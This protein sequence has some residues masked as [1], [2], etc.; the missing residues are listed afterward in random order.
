MDY[1][2]IVLAII[3]VVATVILFLWQTAEDKFDL[4]CILLDAKTGNVSLYKFGQLVALVISS[5]ALVNETRAG[6]LSEWLF[7]FYMTAWS[8]INLVNK[9]LDKKPSSEEPK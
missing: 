6:R 8:G 3:T 5:W 7:V 9:W 1:D 4:R 2:T